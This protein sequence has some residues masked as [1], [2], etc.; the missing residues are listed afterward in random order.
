MRRLPQNFSV[1]LHP[2]RALA[3]AWLL[4]AALLCNAE[5]TQNLGG[6]WKFST[7]KS[8]ANNDAWTQPGYD[9]AGW[10]IMAVPGS[11]D[12]ENDYAHFK[13]TAYYVTQFTTPADWK[14]GFVRLHFGAVY[15]T[16]KVWLN[17]QY[18]GEHVGGYTPFE[19]DVDQV[20]R[21]GETNTLAVSVDNTY[22]RGA[23]W[24]WGGI[25]QKVELI[26]GGQVQ[27][28][29]Q[30]IIAE[31]DLANGTAQV[32]V[33][34][35][36][37]NL[38]DTTFHGEVL[39]RIVSW[40]S[41]KP[42]G[43]L[44][45]KKISLEPGSTQ[46]VELKFAL[47]ADE[48]TLWD[49]DNPYLYELLTRVQQGQ[50]IISK[51]SD[52]FGIR[53]IAT[54][55]AKLLL[56]GK[57]LH[58]SGFNR[59]ATH[60][61]YGQTD[62]E[63]LV[64]F[65]IDAM[66]AMGA[67]FSRI[68]HHAQTPELLAYCDEVGYLLIEEIPVWSKTDPQV[69]PN[70]EQTKIWLKEMINRDFNHPSIIGW[71]VGNE[72]AEQKHKGQQMS[73]RVYEYVRTMIEYVGTL[74]P[75]RLKTYVSNTATGA[76]GP[77]ID[78]NDVVD[79]MMHNSYGGAPGQVEK[80]HKIWP[81]KPIFVSELGKSQVGNHLDEGK[82][83][84]QL[85]EEIVALKNY[86]YVVGCAIWS[87]N[88]YR[89][90]FGGTPA[91]E[92]RAWG[93]YNVWR[94]PK[95]VAYE[96]RE[97]FTDEANDEPLP[98]MALIPAERPVDE[99]YILAAVPLP[100]AIMVGYSVVDENDDYEIS[101]QQDGGATQTLEVRGLKGAAKISDLAP[102][103]YTLKIRALKDGAEWSAPYLVNVSN[104]DPAQVSQN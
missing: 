6:V 19:F 5:Q 82:L 83:H 15:Q 12:T 50:T 58:V 104:D 16:A 92:N 24:K 52:R 21:A 90:H 18:L 95:A 57:E 9:T 31:P 60:R 87:Y 94:Q 102:G 62:P 74:D 59:V 71:S 81:D 34:V 43:K 32:D 26:R 1:H 98:T 56:N 79:I 76:N 39:A 96:M 77:G 68:A 17:G 4:L 29:R 85:K 64:K 93:V 40:K 22:N 51:K 80:L 8:L 99:V 13:G 35:V 11:W 27:V 47:S 48:T 88:D 89:S 78:P 101:Y 46:T 38:G 41:Q 97:L 45:Q 91:T 53:K 84:E 67:R 23:W 66:M 10:A 63:H 70:N 30:M 55:D 72:L 44:A 100:N 7:D 49:L 103:T 75:T 3:F 54:V 2:A 36:L 28:E 73:W 86:D 65:D 20:L 33:R 25:H 61:A 42:H 37:R 69:W 14:S